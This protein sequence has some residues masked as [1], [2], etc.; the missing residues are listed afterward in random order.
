[1]IRVERPAGHIATLNHNSFVPIAGAT[2]LLAVRLVV[3]AGAE[4][5]AIIDVERQVRMLETRLDVIHPSPT[6]RADIASTSDTA[7]IISD[8]YLGAKSTPGGAQVERV[9]LFHRGFRNG[10]RAPAFPALASS[11]SPGVGLLPH[12]SPRNLGCGAGCAI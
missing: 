6:G 7:M 8:Q 2:A 3:A 4:R 12:P 5:A 11:R 10:E 1:M 9:C